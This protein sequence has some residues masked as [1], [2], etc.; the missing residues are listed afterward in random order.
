MGSLER[1]S[2]PPS[3]PAVIL[4]YCCKLPQLGPGGALAAKKA[5]LHSI[6]PNGLS[7]NLLCVCVCVCV[8]GGGYSPL[9]P[10]LK[11]AHDRKWSKLADHEA[12]CWHA[13]MPPSGD[14]LLKQNFASQV[15][16]HSHYRSP[17][18]AKQAVIV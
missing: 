4:G 14:A 12:G 11:C 15:A 13:V 7:W 5:F 8:G 17:D 3:P 16:Y 9:A 18:N 1:G 2:Q 6:A 10:P